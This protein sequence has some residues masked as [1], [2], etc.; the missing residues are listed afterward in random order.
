VALGLAA[1]A[2]PDL[3]IPAAKIPAPAVI[4]SRRFMGIP[5]SFFN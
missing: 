1:N 5:R 3:S 2:A 4:I